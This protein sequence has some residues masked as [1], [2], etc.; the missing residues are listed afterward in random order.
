MSEVTKESCCK[1][2]LFLKVLGKRADG[3]HNIETVFYPI[4]LYDY[5]KISIK[6]CGIRLNCSHP[7]LPTDSRNLVY[8]AADTFLKA[9]GKP[10]LGVEIYLDK[11]LPIAAGIGAGSSN[12]ATTL[13]GLNELF[14]FPLTKEKLFSL[15]ATLGSDVP[16]FLNPKPAL[17]TGRGEKLQTLTPFQSLQETFMVLVYPG[18]GVSTAW[19]YKELSKYPELFSTPITAERFVNSLRNKSLEDAVEEFFNSFETPVF[20]KFPILQM[21]KEFL[22]G[23]G[24][25]VSLMSGSGSTTFA[26]VKSRETA[27]TLRKKFIEEFG[28]TVWS[29]IVKL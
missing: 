24:A 11:R 10:D 27:E 22:T 3:Y 4:A 20:K 29:A 17:A 5:L 23:A 16:F 21:Y 14:G 18:F 26:I 19:A 25:T 15:A 7:D 2:N 8:K 1:V 28:I 12:A 13:L 6:G 9:I